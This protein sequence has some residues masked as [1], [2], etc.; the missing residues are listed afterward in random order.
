MVKLKQEVLNDQVS[1]FKI[2]DG[3]LKLDNRYCV[4]NMDNLRQ[5]ILHEAHF[6]PYSV[7]PGAIKMY[8]DIKAN[9]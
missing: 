7:H 4:P 3:M 1:N 2:V 5:K 6:A 9:Y 8:H